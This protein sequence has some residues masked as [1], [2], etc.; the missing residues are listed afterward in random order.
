VSTPG[1]SGL[2]LRSLLVRVENAAPTDTVAVL[3]Q[4]LVHSWRAD[5][6]G[7]LIA[8]YGGD[9]LIRLA[10]ASSDTQAGLTVQRP[11]PVSRPERAVTGSSA[12]DP[13]TVRIAGSPQGQ[14]LR[15]QQPLVV[16]DAAGSWAYAPVSSRGEAIGVL[17]V[18]LPAPPGAATGRDIAA[19]AHLLAYLVVTNRR[20]TDQF[21][22]GQRPSALDLAAEIQRRLLPASFTCD[23]ASCTIAGWLEPARSAAGDT[24]DYVL[25]RGL[26]H[27]SLTDAM[28]HSVPA[29][30]LASLAVAALRQSRRR[31]CT[32]LQQAQFADQ[33]LL[34]HSRPDEF[35]TGLLL[36]AD[37]ATGVTSL[38]NAGHP[39]PYLLRDGGVE[40]L[41]VEPDL[42][43]G[44]FPDTGYRVHELALRRG[45]RLVVVTD[46]VIE[47]NAADLDLPR[48][49]VTTR[50]LHPR[51]TV[52]HLI[53]QV[54]AQGELVDDATVLCL[55]WHAGEASFRADAGADVGRAS[56]PSASS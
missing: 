55:D 50:G 7:F 53:R 34:G 21:E 56:R 42:P 33:T 48:E 45:D 24:F 47:R 49:L 38:I 16:T 1:G 39:P 19:A 10:H 9:H 37:L 8:D 52:Q 11:P 25:D 29:A 54:A 28:G 43:F 30:Q 46:G 26:L 36:R 5:T 12:D 22:W 4:E 14:V 31:G 6:V 23:A 35:V 32:L 44:M 18:R 17:E 13:W 15:T 20:Y 3:A 41:D 2:D 40:V 51:E 27:A